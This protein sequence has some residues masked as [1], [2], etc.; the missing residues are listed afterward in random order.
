MSSK[1]D[2]IKELADEV[3]KVANNVVDEIYRHEECKLQN[4][5]DS[6][7]IN[8]ANVDFV[9]SSD[10]FLQDKDA[11]EEISDFTKN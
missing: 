6:I 2:E 11:S 1:D 9:G 8:E 5:L 4:I 10:L 7:L 3:F